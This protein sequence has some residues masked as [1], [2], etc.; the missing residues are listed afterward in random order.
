MSGKRRIQPFQKCIVFHGNYDDI[1][2]AVARISSIFPKEYVA[3]L[4][5]LY[6]NNGGVS[7]V[8]INSELDTI[9]SWAILYSNCNA[10]FAST[11]GP[12]SQIQN[13]FLECI[14]VH[15]SYLENLTH[16][17]LSISQV[18]PPPTTTTHYHYQ[19]KT[20]SQEYFVAGKS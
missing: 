11:L 15:L 12:F 2:L 19:N 13:H 7:C 14:T 1:C 10:F 18:A 5:G 20:L 8:E 4:I 9:I 16:L 6:K 3:S 17:S